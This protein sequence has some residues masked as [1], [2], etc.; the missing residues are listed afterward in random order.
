MSL[1]EIIKRSDIIVDDV[2]TK[3]ISYL[4]N[5]Y[6]WSQ[7]RAEDYKTIIYNVYNNGQ[8]RE[9]KRVIENYS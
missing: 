1:T 7:T 3:E 8:R 6:G 9:T 4:T 2:L 5:K